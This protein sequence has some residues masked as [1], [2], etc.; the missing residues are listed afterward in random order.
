MSGIMSG[1]MSA[2][3]NGGTGICILDRRFRPV[4]MRNQAGDT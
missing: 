3:A 4:R 2:D 1:I